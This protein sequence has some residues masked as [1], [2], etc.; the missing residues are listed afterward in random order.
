MQPKYIDLTRLLRLRS[1]P[2]RALQHRSTASVFPLI[3]PRAVRHLDLCIPSPL[4]Q[5]PEPEPQR[6]KKSEASN[7]EPGQHRSAPVSPRNQ[8]VDAITSLS[9]SGQSYMRGHPHVRPG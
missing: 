7:R 3:I 5:E 1:L 4:D 6:N 8:T 2:P 9:P